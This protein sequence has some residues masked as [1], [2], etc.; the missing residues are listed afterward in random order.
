MSEGSGARADTLPVLHN[1]AM[2]FMLDTAINYTTICMDI[3]MPRTL[4][5]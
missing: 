5:M 3:V 1:K 4:L 2:L